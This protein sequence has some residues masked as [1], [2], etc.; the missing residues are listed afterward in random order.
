MLLFAHAHFTEVHVMSFRIKCLCAVSYQVIRAENDAK[1][2]IRLIVAGSAPDRCPK[3]GARPRRGLR[4]LS[5]HRPKEPIPNPDPI[6]LAVGAR[7]AAPTANAPFP[8]CAPGRVSFAL[9]EAVR[10]GPR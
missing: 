3:P 4:I 2:C 10:P 7:S 5:Q 1:A 9:I 6:K 8:W